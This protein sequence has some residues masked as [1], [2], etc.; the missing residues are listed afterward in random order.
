MKYLIVAVL[1][2]FTLSAN[3]ANTDQPSIEQ[4]KLSDYRV[5]EKWIWEFKGVTTQG[6]VRSEGRDARE[7]VEDNGVLSIKTQHGLI[8]VS[9][10][11]KPITSDT[12]RFK[13]PLEVGKKW[14]YESH[15]ES[16]DGTTGKTVQN[17][18]VLSYKEETVGAGKFM[19]FTIAYKGTVSNSRG[20]IADSEE[21]YVY[22]PEVKNFIKLTQTQ[23]D[24]HYVEELV[25]Y[26]KP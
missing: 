18:E 25:E 17:V 1:A 21:V 15:W 22:S 19:A 11:V 13:W 9:N 10:I 5:G 16:E 4:P 7:V 3:S 20:Y 14:V 12:P 2:L 23:D 26:S 24:F 6:E 8:P